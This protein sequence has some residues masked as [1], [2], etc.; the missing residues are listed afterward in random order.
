M[1]KFVLLFFLEMITFAFSI[2]WM[3]S[4]LQMALGV[5]TMFIV[6][7][8]GLMVIMYANTRTW[9]QICKE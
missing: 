9:R 6:G 8:L 5:E 3:Y 1:K 4:V 7:A 2:L